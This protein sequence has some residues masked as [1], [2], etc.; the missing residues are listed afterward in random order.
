MAL[1]GVE[2]FLFT[3]CTTTAAWPH[4]PAAV[5]HHATEG[6]SCGSGSPRPQPSGSRPAGVRAARLSGSGTPPDALAAEAS[7]RG[8]ASDLVPAPY[9]R[10]P[11]DAL[12]LDGDRRLFDLLVAWDPEV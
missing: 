7:A 6:R 9:G 5:D 10:I 12:E 4:A 1:D 8:T 2:D 11:V 3:C